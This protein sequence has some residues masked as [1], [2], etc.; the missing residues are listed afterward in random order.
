MGWADG[1]RER[2][3]Q[4]LSFLTKEPEDLSE[5]KHVLSAGGD[6]SFLNKLWDFFL[7]I[8]KCNMDLL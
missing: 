2:E 6:Y 3:N 5:A 7:M 4:N 8:I 1:N